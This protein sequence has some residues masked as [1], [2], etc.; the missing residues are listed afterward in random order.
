MYVVDNLLWLEKNYT[1][2][3]IIGQAFFGFWIHSKNVLHTAKNHFS[4]PY[5]QF[6]F[7]PIFDHVDK[8]GLLVPL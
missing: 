6:I 3:R 2:D 1:H 7:K 5:S 8:I 4:L